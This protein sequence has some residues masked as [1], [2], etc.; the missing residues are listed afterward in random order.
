MHIA[1]IKVYNSDN[2]SFTNIDSFLLDVC[3]A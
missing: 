3:A 2:I 1:Q